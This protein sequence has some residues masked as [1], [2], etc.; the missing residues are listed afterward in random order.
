MDLPAKQP[1]LLE[2]ATLISSWA[3]IQDIRLTRSSIQSK[4][5]EFTSTAPLRHTFD[6]VTGLNLDEKRLIVSVSLTVSLDELVRIEADYHLNYSI[7]KAP[8]IVSSEVAAAFGKLNGVYNAWPYWREYVQSTS[9]RIGLPPIVLPLVTAASMLAYY[10]EK[11]KERTISAVALE[12]QSAVHEP[13]LADKD[14]Q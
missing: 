12:R 11:E 3:E 9:N 7:S 5:E 2:L 10:A 14:Q 6:A 8:F 13:V 1:S 4:I